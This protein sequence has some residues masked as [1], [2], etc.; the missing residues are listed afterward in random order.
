MLVINSRA[1]LRPRHQP[2]IHV[3]PEQQ[4]HLCLPVFF[5]RRLIAGV[6]D[7]SEEKYV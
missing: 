6:I 4:R 3:N 7:L 1:A 5:D 2:K